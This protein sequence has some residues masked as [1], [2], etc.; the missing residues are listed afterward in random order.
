MEIDSPLPPGARACVSPSCSPVL[1]RERRR[2]ATAAAPPRRQPRSPASRCA[3]P[4]PQHPL[5]LVGPTPPAPPR[6]REHA[7]AERPGNVEAGQGLVREKETPSRDP[8][9]KNLDPPLLCICYF[10]CVCSCLV[11]FL[12][13][14]RKIQKLQN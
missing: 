5:G 3:L 14:H 7:G 2:A 6:R 1:H 9:A 11:K 8:S 13:N 10:M 4:P 12:E